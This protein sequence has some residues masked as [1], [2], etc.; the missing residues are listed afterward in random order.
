MEEVEKLKSTLDSFI[1][2]HEEQNKVLESSL[3]KVLSSLNTLAGSSGTEDKGSA[4]KGNA[5]SPPPITLANTSVHMR[6]DLSRFHQQV[7]TPPPAVTA[8]VHNLQ[9]TPWFTKEPSGEDEDEGNA[10]CP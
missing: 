10:D 2:K 6:N 3:D 8:Q 5:I 9:S 7:Y 4:F 1:L